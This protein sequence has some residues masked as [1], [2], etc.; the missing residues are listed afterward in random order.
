MGRFRVFKSI[1]LSPVA[2]LYGLGVWIRN[3]LYDSHILR[4]RTVPIP[5]IGVGNLAVGG[6]GKTPMTEYIVS[7][8][9]SH[10]FR[11]A[12]L[13]R[14]YG[15]KTRG[16]RLADDNDTALTI[17]D[18]PMQMHRHFPNV[19]VAVCADRV[20]G[21]HQ[22]Q[23]LHPDLQCVVLDDAFQHRRLRCGY[24]VLL[25]PYD[26]LY[27]HDRLLPCG[28]LRDLPKQS[29][30]A[31]TIVVT[32]CPPTMQP[33]DCRV[34]SNTLRLPS[35]QHL[36]FARICYPPLRLPGTPLVVTGIANP[37]YLFRYV[38][39]QYPDAQLLAFPDH[40]TFT[41][42]DIE[43][44]LA[45]ADAY[46]CVLTTEKDRMRFEQTVLPERLGSKLQVLPIEIDLGGDKK[47][48]DRDILM[49]VAE[50]NRKTNNL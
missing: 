7:L 29:L 28:H 46:D 43:S 9:L 30:R 40:H 24:Y 5:T 45:Q 10:G 36:C 26:R 17:G 12:I 2:W 3:E 14:G 22:L 44:I 23:A 33:I 8:L 48:F 49:Y 13:S 31:N 37:E 27:V 38:Q 41:D 11:V 50:N 47:T 35:Y 20:Q 34:V 4:S 18:E 1:V 42:A 32:K 21:V 19:P 16:F 25:T 15:R 6:T 39:Q